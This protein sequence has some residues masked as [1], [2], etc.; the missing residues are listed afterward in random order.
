MNCKQHRLNTSWS[1][2][3]ISSQR[4]SHH[5]EDLAS[6]QRELCPGNLTRS[7]WEWKWWQKMEGP[8]V[9]N[10]LLTN[11]C[12]ALSWCSTSLLSWEILRKNKENGALLHKNPRLFNHRSTFLKS[13]FEI[14][15]WL[16]WGKFINYC[17]IVHPIRSNN[18]KIGFQP[19]CTGHVLLYQP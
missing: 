17:F 2:L 18:K 15:R 9:T 8:R 3:F 14:K 4:F 6:V 19:N 13:F 7:G 1:E 5:H 10:R 11:K 16:L 12:K